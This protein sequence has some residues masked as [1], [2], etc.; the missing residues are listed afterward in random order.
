MDYLWE[1][2]CFRADGAGI[3]EELS[4]EGFFLKL[5]ILYFIPVTLALL[6]F[7]KISEKEKRVLAVSGLCLSCYSLCVHIGYVV[8]LI[9]LE[10]VYPLWLYCLAPFV[11]IAGLSVNIIRCWKSNFIQKD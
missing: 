11:W 1:Y 8:Y 10:D 3:G 2:I 5:C 7:L 9:S 4:Y 6:R